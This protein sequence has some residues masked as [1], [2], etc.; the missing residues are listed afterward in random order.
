M[1]PARHNTI[2]KKSYRLDHPIS[3]L[4][5]TILSTTLL[6]IFSASKFLP[7]ARPEFFLVMHR[8]QGSGKESMETLNDFDT[9]V[10][11]FECLKLSLLYYDLLA[12]FE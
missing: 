10:A 4:A 2:R 9:N 5:T 3:I 6:I 8:L 1:F 11:N 12:Y 7:L